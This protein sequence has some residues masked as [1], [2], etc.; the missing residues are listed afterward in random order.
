MSWCL[1]P[2][3]AGHEVEGLDLGLYEG[4]DL[5][6]RPGRSARAPAGHEGCVVCTAVGDHALLCLAALSNHPLGNLYPAAT[7]SVNLDGTNW[8]LGL[9]GQAGRSWH[10]LVVLLLQ[11]VLARPGLE[12]VAEDA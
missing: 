6:P 9:G 12:A 11:P 8:R 10:V 4:C 1:L 7:Y 5:G 2:R 3:A